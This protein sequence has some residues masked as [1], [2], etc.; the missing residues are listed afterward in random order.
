MYYN[1]IDITAS[2]RKLAALCRSKGLRANKI[3]AELHITRQA[4]YGWL[5]G[6]YLPSVDNLYLLAQMLDTTVDNIL[7][8][9]TNGDNAQKM[10]KMHT[11]KGVP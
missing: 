5:Q 3:E 8:P 6:R 4:V 9:T 1:T 2:A 10:E 7:I 11:T